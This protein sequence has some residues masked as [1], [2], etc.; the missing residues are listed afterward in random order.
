MS[1][2]V[3]ANPEA[4]PAARTLSRVDHLLALVPS[5]GTGILFFVVI[6]AILNADRNEREALRRAEAEGSE[7]GS[8]HDS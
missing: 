4:P 3:T 1:L 8:P 7:T 5:I 2:P 6:R